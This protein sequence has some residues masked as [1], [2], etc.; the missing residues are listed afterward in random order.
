M[1]IS[2]VG[3]E[4]LQ[5]LGVSTG[6]V[7]YHEADLQ[8]KKNLSPKGLKFCLVE[9]VKLGCFSEINIKTYNFN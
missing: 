8:V 9:M 5:V 6:R 2:K 7:F 4:D 1:N 3:F